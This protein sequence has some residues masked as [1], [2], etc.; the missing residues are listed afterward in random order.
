MQRSIALCLFGRI[1]I[2]VAIVLFT[3][4]AIESSS[5]KRTFIGVICLISSILFAFSVHLLIIVSTTISLSSLS[6]DQNVFYLIK[7][8]Q[9]VSL[10]VTKSCQYIPFRK[11][12]FSFIDCCMWTAYSMIHKFHLYLFVSIFLFF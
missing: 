1:T 2:V 6:I 3:L 10:E 11:V 5:A 4:F 7:Q 9:V 8:Q 12:C